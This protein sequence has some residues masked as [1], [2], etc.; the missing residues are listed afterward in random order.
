MEAGG[1]LY[2]EPTLLPLRQT[3]PGNGAMT[4]GSLITASAARWAAASAVFCD[5]A[6]RMM[7]PAGD[8]FRDAG[9]GLDD[10]FAVHDGHGEQ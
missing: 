7:F 6:W 9:S 1:A 5:A 4:P 10:E 2:L 8:A 3:P